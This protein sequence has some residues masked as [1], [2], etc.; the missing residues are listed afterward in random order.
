[1]LARIERQLA[2]HMGPFASLLVR[3]AATRA[4]DLPALGAQLAAVLAD[5]ARLEFGQAFARLTAGSPDM[6]MVASSSP[7][8][9]VAVAAAKVSAGS[10]ASAA[11]TSPGSAIEQASIDAVAIKLAVYVGPIAKM[12]AS[13]EARHAASFDEFVQRVEACIG[14]A[15]QRRRFRYDLDSSG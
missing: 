8:S 13:R 15:A 7:G 5:T 4:N 9:G 12:I 1:M 14:D 6:S 2:I 10:P 11:G 3:R